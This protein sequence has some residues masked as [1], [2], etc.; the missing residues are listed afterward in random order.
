MTGCKKELVD[1]NQ[2]GS[3]LPKE[4]SPKEFLVTTSA[5]PGGSVN[6]V[7]TTIVKSGSSVIVSISSD[8]SHKIS[9]IKIDG[10]DQAIKDTLKLDNISKNREIVINFV[11][12]KALLLTDKRGW[13]L[14][15]LRYWQDGKLVADLILGKSDTDYR[16]YFY[17]DGTRGSAEDSSSSVIKGIGSQWKF[18]EDEKHIIGFGDNCLIV[19]LTPDTFVFRES[20][21]YYHKPAMFEQTFVHP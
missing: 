13:K 14:K 20:S 1:P 3:N 5:N 2:N 11:S 8:S 4:T 12:K 18:S 10:I 15:F 17:S 7:G 19:K 16:F 21:D 6:P 9:S